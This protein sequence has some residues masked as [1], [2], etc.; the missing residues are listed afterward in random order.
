MQAVAFCVVWGM[1]PPG[2]A[3]WTRLVALL[4]GALLVLVALWSTPTARFP[5]LLTIATMAAAAL[6]RYR[7][8][9]AG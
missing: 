7:T 9:V 6:M 3:V 2:T 8:H 1:C 4:L 5:I